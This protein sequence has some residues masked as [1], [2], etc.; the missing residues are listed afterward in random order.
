MLLITL[1]GLPS[2]LLINTPN[3]AERENGCRSEIGQAAEIND[4]V[5]SKLTN[6]E[7]FSHACV[8][9]YSMP[10]DQYLTRVISRWSL[11]IKNGSRQAIKGNLIKLRFLD[12]T[13]AAPPLLS[14][15]FGNTA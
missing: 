11:L 10:H 7:R 5:G 13:G 12:S 14:F 6:G 2:S 4:S 3:L 1:S 15:A 9:R 8:W